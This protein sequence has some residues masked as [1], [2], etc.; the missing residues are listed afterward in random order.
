ML[1]IKAF[2]LVYSL[3]HG[4]FNAKNVWIVLC[5]YCLFCTKNTPKQY[6]ASQIYYN[7]IYAES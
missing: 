7:Y 4:Q 2:D 1:H 3:S 6:F 5:A